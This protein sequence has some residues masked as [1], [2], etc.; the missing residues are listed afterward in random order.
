M[1][2]SEKILNSFFSLLMFF[3]EINLAY[4]VYTYNE[5]QCI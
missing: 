4:I 3:C 1:I 2:M 5:T